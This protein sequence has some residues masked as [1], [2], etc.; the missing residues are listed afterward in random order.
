MVQDAP[1]TD[2]PSPVPAPAM[3]ARAPEVSRAIYGMPMFV[4]LS[5]RDM[6]ATTSWYTEALGFVVLFS[7]PGADG[8]PSLVHLRRWQF[9]DL[10]I[11]PAAGSVTAGSAMSL[12]VAAVYGEMEALAK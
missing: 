12:S 2:L 5:A 4:N 3:D 11:H 1:M 8:R 7:A 9:Q 6:D 10:L